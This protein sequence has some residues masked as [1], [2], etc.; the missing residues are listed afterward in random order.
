MKNSEKTETNTKKLKVNTKTKTKGSDLVV[1]TLIK[2]G[3]DT[4]FGYPGGAIM[5]VYDSL[6]DYTDKINHILVRHEQGAGHAA[7][8]YARITGKPGVC[9]VTSGPGAT[10][11]VTAIADAMMDSIPIICITGQVPAAVVGTDAFQETDVIGIT[12]PIT[13]WNF[14]ITSA[15]EIPFVLEKAFYIAVSGRPGPVVIDLTKNAQ[16]EEVD[17]TTLKHF[18]PEKDSP[19]YQPI[20]EPNAKQIKIASELINQSE[21][22]LALI[23][24]GVIIA[25]AQKEILEFVEK[26]NIPA[27]C[28]LHGLSA[29]P[30]DHPCYAGF[31]GMHGNYAPNM[32]TQQADLIIALGMRF[33]DRV[34]GKLEKYAPNAKVIHIDIDPAEL[35][36]NV[37]AEVPIVADVKQALKHLL[38]SVKFRERKEWFDLMKKYWDVENK[39]VIQNQINSSSNQIKMAEVVRKISNLTKGKATIVAD[40]GQH[41]MIS[42]RYY[43]FKRFNSFISSGGMGTMGFGIPAGIGVKI[44]RP[45]EE[46][47]AIVGDG[48]A[49]M[50]IQ[51]LGTIAQERLPLKIVILNNNYLGMVRQWQEL[52]FEKRY[53]FTYLLNPDFV[54][55]AE[56][57]G[58]KAE[59]VKDKKDLNQALE[60]MLS[61]K[62]PY[63]LEVVVEKE[64]NVFPMVP[65]GWSLDQILLSPEDLKK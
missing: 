5:P 39:V 37:K 19:S 31:L 4:V 15:E 23:G 49:Q 27:A 20:Y 24:H 34:T 12:A 18:D 10:N 32:M 46:V 53:S 54:K 17:E 2:L 16:F 58:I 55:V 36:K 50:T 47:I 26:A 7:E 30:T 43:E 13:K 42:A 21:K 60:K 63:V 25:N 45:N 14:Q 38:K 61:A 22:P 57:Y 33:D 29:I 51:E 64:D 35:N 44:A 52:F 8:G 41:Q 28:T 9:M 56:G 59:R 65:S 40:V 1:K 6:L 11:L 48:G 3:V 62:E